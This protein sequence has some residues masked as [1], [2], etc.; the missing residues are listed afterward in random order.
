MKATLSIF[1]HIRSYNPIEVIEFDS[2]QEAHKAMDKLD[3]YTQPADI[4]TDRFICR[5]FPNLYAIMG[6]ES[7]NKV[8]KLYNDRDPSWKQECAA[9]SMY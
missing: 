4:T 8:E 5:N 7:K 2:T 9:V 1:D 3:C 6:Y